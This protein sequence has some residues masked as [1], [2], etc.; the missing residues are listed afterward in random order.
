MSYTY[1]VELERNNQEVVAFPWEGHS[2]GVVTFAHMHLGH[3]NSET[4]PHIG[5]KAHVPTGRVA[6]EDFIHFL[7]RD[8]GVFSLKSDWQDIL[9]ETRAPFLE[10]KTW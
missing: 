1:A 9:S 8:L 3:A 2:A 5:P 7:I 10:R 4:F 6:F